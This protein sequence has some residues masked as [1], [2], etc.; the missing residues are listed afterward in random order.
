MII[1]GRILAAVFAACLIAACSPTRAIESIAVLQGL[2][3]ASAKT[4]PEQ[5]PQRLAHRFEVAGRT[6]AADL[7]V[8]RDG[9]KAALV[10][11][12]G[13]TPEG[14][15]DRRLVAF[16]ETM[17][18]A[19]FLVLVPDIETLR[20]LRVSP[21]DVTAIADAVEHLSRQAAVS[22]VGL[23]AISYSAGPAL[24]AALQ[25][26]SRRRV[27]FLIT[28][29]GYYDIEAV[30]AFFTTGH[31]RESPAHPW[32]RIEPNAYGKWIFLKSNLDQIGDPHDRSLLREI[33]ELRLRD[34][35]AGIGHLAAQLGHEGKAVYA[36]VVN[37]DPGRVSGLIAALPEGIRSHMARLSP[38]AFGLD[39][40]AAK[41]FLVH[42]RDDQI[43][44]FT[45][46]LA[47]RAAA[48]ERRADLYIVRSL[49]HVD[50]SPVGWIDF[51]KLWRAIY[52]VLEFRDAMPAPNLRSILAI[53]R[54]HSA[55]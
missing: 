48:P 47:L 13:V 49:A 38:K 24:I 23:V 17:S 10:L 34:L 55:T 20:D 5:G 28:I 14:K 25:D 11:V 45:E 51:L 27:S 53:T 16:A 29:G 15:D 9:A 22:E 4:A 46:S 21:G 50:L 6:Y 41:L 31:F 35:E 2:S 37:R 44:P 12:P 32:Q 30:A 42:G 7:Y 26:R 39:R 54:A 36:L 8:P 33:A 1:S 18:R 43:I 19:R 3:G 52:R 40:L